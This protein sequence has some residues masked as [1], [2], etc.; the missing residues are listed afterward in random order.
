MGRPGQQATSG[1][2]GQH[3]DTFHTGSPRISFGTARS[4]A[5]ATSVTDTRPLPWELVRVGLLAVHAD[6]RAAVRAESLL[7]PTRPPVPQ[8]QSSQS[9]HEVQLRRPRIA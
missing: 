6:V 2:L 5:H 4:A 9:G 7:M 8:L 3:G 1:A